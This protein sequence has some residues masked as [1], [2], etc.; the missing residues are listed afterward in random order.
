MGGGVSGFMMQAPFLWGGNAESRTELE[1]G[2]AVMTI[3]G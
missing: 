1:P 2:P 3:E